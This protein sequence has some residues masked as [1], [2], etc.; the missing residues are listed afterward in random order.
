MQNVDYKVDEKKGTLTIVV[1]LSKR[2]G[3]S[4]TGNTVNISST[5]GNQKIGMSDIAFGLTVYTKDKLDEERLKAA[6]SKG[7]DTWESYQKALK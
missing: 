5:Q 3:L 7:Y 6:K 2:F 1:D 4:G